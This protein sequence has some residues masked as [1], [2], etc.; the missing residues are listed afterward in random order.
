MISFFTEVVGFLLLL[1]F[2][3]FFLEDR[4]VIDHFDPIRYKMIKIQEVFGNI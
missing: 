3:L 4:G 2:V 1:L